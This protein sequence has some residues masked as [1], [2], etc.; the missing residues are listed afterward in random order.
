M[1]NPYMVFVT[2]GHGDIDFHV[3]ETIAEED[4]MKEEENEIDAIIE[5]LPA[6]IVRLVGF[7]NNVTLWTDENSWKSV[8]ERGYWKKDARH[9]RKDMFWNERESDVAFAWCD[10]MQHIM[11]ICTNLLVCVKQ[12]NSKLKPGYDLT[13]A[14]EH[15]EPYMEA[16]KAGEASRWAYVQKSVEALTNLHHR[17][18]YES[19]RAKIECKNASLCN[20]YEHFAN[21]TFE[22]CDAFLHILRRLQ[23]NE[24]NWPSCVTSMWHH[25][26]HAY[27]AQCKRRLANSRGTYPLAEALEKLEKLPTRQ[28]WSHPHVHS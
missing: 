4:E 19:M 25:C 26:G 14:E 20:L 5:A 8:I 12:Q 15:S 2:S 17:V 16:R 11:T 1:A 9:H 10:S 13:S 21:H 7:L 22:F 23:A 24:E 27:S 28:P 6:S 18:K 3:F